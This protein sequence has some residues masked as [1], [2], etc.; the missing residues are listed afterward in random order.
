MSI[1][2]ASELAYLAEQK[3]G[4]LATKVPDGTVQNNPVGF[5]VKAAEGYVDIG[6]HGLGGSRKFRNIQAD[7]HVSL[8]VDDLSTEHG[9]QVRGVEIRGRA[10]AIVDVDPPMPGFSREIIRIHPE[11]I[12]S[13]G[14]DG[15]SRRNV[16]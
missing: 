14:L 13:W 1:F 2:T 9:W 12:L 4:R 6:G 11:R 8:V 3:L 5:F 7:P 16:A 10:E 15:S